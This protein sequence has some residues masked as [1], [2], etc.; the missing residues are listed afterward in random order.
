MI[1]CFHRSCEVRTK[2]NPIRDTLVMWRAPVIAVLAADQL[3]GFIISEELLIR[4]IKSQ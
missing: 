1:S 3:V 2:L 4:W